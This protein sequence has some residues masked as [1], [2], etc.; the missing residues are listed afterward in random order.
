LTG[1]ADLYGDD[2]R[3]AYNSINFITCHDGF[4]LHDLVAYNSKH[5]EANGENNSDGCDDNHS[6]NCGVE[7]D[8]TDAGVLAL[9]RQLMKNHACALFF[10][11]GTPMLLGGDE[12]ARTQRGNNNAYCQDNAI[13]WFDWDLAE[14]ND[15]LVEFF[16]KVIA[17]VGRHPVLERR[18]FS[19]CEDLDDDQIPDF[20]WFATD[21]SGDPRWNDPQSRTVCMQLDASTTPGELVGQ[22]LFFIYNAHFEAQHVHLPVLDD[23]TPWHRAIDTSL[24]AGSDIADEGEEIPL[25]PAEF[26]LANPR[27]TVVLIGKA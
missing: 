3:S 8:T 25:N 6:W 7:G 10:A 20:S 9:R 2:G 14:K 23:G 5:N 18:R 22:R 27:S 11:S 12:F 15:D 21:G 17:F 4:T 1:S 26:Y 13:S 16:R 24:A 19:L